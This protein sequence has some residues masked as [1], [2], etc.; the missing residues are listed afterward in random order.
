[1]TRKNTCKTCIHWDM[2]GRATVPDRVQCRCKRFPTD[3]IKK[4]A[5]DWCGE[6]QA[7]VIK[8]K[9]KASSKKKAAAKKPAPEQEPDD[10]LPSPEDENTSNSPPVV[11]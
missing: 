3:Q 1:M 10:V 11:E 5:L 9:K 7:E 2:G 6:H 8:P 4:T